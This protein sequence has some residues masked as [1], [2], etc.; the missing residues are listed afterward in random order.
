[1]GFIGGLAG[2]RGGVV[3]CEERLRSRL[4]E[5]LGPW[6]LAGPSREIARGA[7]LDHP[8]QHAQRRRLQAAGQR[9]RA[10]LQR[11]GL[12]PE[13]ACALFQWVRSERALHLQEALAA[14]GILVRRFGDPAGLRFGLPGSEVDWQRLEAALAT[15]QVQGQGQG[16]G[17]DR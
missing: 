6:T 11:A 1:M 13:G 17:H 5:G 3:L 12:E 2:A 16:Q 14:Q 10:L 9:L 7:L 4:R 15:V 8:W